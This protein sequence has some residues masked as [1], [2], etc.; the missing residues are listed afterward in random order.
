M[1]ETDENDEIL[2]TSEKEQLKGN[3]WEADNSQICILSPNFQEF[4][5]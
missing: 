4:Y 2:M 3:L 1:F 5:F